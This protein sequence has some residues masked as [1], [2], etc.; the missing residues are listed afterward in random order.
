MMSAKG[1]PATAAHP[2][3]AYLRAVWRLISAYWRS[4]ERWAARGLLI[5]VIALDFLLV[6]RAVL[7]TYWQKDFYDTLAA[8]D[9]AAF[10]LLLGQLAMLALVG[11]LVETGRAYS[12]QSLE[13]RWRSWLTASFLE[14]WLGQDAHWRIALDGAMENVDQR[15]AEDLK[16]LASNVL[17]LFLKLLKNTANL[18]SF[19]FIVWELSGVI[20]VSLAGRQVEIA[21]YMLWAAL[22]YALLGSVTMEWLGRRMVAVDYRQQ[23]TEADFRFLLVRVREHGEQIALLGGAQAERVGL[24]QRF[25]AIRSNWRHIMTYTKRI[26][27]ADRSYTE[28]G[29]MVPYLLCG[30]RFF[31]GA[32]SLGGL[33]QLVQA[34]M[35]VRT[36]FSWFIYEF[37][38]LALLR[39][40]L[41]RLVELDLALDEGP[42]PPGLRRR[43]RRYAGLRVR[44]LRVTAPDGTQLVGPLSWTILPGQRWL[45][46]GA[47]GAGKSTLLRTLA[48]LWPHCSGVISAPARSRMLFL[49]QQSYLPQ[50]SLRQCL[51]YP[52]SEHDVP[53]DMCRR[54]LRA[55]GLGSLEPDFMC[56]RDWTQ[57]LSPGERQKLAFAR[58]LVQRPDFVFLDEATSA[59]DANSETALYRLLLTYCPDTAIVSAAHREGLQRFHAD[60]LAL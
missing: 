59:L 52:A 31:A 55:V 6:Y 23:Q 8:H 17:N 28:I 7:I 40:V 5:L 58:V 49:P 60:V 45:L 37:K 48:G 22:L 16:W 47:S 20:S 32:L 10:W 42:A 29:A 57:R 24:R 56:E 4:A 38:E 18:V 12:V 34:F 50:G 3:A 21:G 25:D 53:D 54:A 36:A 2:R 39:S 15:I 14:R 1:A 44:S 13:M 41:R 51:S 33:I 43:Q 30:P 9:L 35:R 11:V 19:S 46:T 27:L 26:T